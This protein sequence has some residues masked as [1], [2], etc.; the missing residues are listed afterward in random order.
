MSRLFGTISVYGFLIAGAMALAVLYMR[1]QEKRLLLPRDSSL[2]LA[3]WVIPAGIIGARIY[4]V[5]F[6]WE[7]YAADPLSVLYI[8]RGGLAIYGG[9][10]GGTAGALLLARVKKLPFGKLMDMLAPAL[11]LGQAIGRWGNFFNQEAYGNPVTDPAWQ[12]FPYAVRIGEAWFQATFF[13]ESLWDFLGFLL[14][15]AIRKKIRRPGD[16]FACYLCYYGLGRAFIEGLRSDSLWWGSVRVSQA[17]AA[18][19]F[20]GAGVFVWIRETGKH[21]VSKDL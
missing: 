8:W 18:A 14:L 4:Y 17:L 19:L 9:V 16:L 20:I 13:Y 10:I 1:C 5:A 21:A 2:D 12:F 3:L 7:Q 15:H 11:I 6:S